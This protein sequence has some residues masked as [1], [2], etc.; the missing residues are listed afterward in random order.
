[1]YNS[2]PTVHESLQHPMQV[3]IFHFSGLIYQVRLGQIGQVRS[4][5]AGLGKLTYP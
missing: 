5:N 4:R 3:L 2:P 1:M